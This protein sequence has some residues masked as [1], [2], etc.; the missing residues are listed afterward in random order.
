MTTAA[1]SL[2]GNKIIDGIVALAESN[3]WQIDH[4]VATFEEMRDGLMQNLVTQ[5]GEAAFEE[6]LMARRDDLGVEVH[7][8]VLEL[9]GQSV[10]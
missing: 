8:D 6:W 10:S 4:S 2:F 5:R 9:I 3:E 7:D 1:T